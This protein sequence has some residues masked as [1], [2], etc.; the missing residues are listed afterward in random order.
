MVQEDIITSLK[1]DPTGQYISLGD[2]AGRVILFKA[3]DLT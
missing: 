2:N 3:T 1:F